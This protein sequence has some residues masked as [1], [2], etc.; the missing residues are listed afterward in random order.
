MDT[1]TTCMQPGD[2]EDGRPHPNLFMKHLEDYLSDNPH[3]TMCPS[4]GHPAYGDAVRVLERPS[5]ETYVGANYFMA[6][7]SILKTSEDFINAMD[8]AYQLSASITDYLQKYSSFTKD[9]EV[10]PYRW[11]GG[12]GGGGG[13]RGLSRGERRNIELKKRN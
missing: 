8:F 11:V 10:F 3:D 5:G 12:W 1:A 13:G 7:H 4:A 6:Y 9:I 2:F